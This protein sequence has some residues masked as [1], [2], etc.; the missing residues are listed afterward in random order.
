M[1]FEVISVFPAAFASYLNA[2]ILKRAQERGLI[3][4]RLHGLRGWGKG[5]HRQ[6]DDKP[7]GG[8]AGMVLMAEPILRAVDKSI[9]YTFIRS[10]RKE[11]KNLKSYKRKTKIVLLSAKGKQFNQK[12]A[13]DWAKRYERLI[14]ISGR[15]EGIDERVRLALKAEEVS[16][17]PY[18]L[19]DGDVAAM[20]AISAVARLIP[21]VIKLDSLREE[22]H[23][24]FIV[25]REAA[26]GSGAEYPHYTRPEMLTWKGRAYRVP[27]VLLS[28][29]HRKVA[30]WREAHR[31]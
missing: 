30:A 14:I 8:G 11:L 31:H 29:D 28:G 6:L 18:V 4:I 21:G 27:G 7:Y 25:K 5:A 15:Y 10:R 19:T 26:G 9:R 1:R 17:G 23:G 20:V 2:S 22:S 3:S 24:N 12:M 13:Y 16:I